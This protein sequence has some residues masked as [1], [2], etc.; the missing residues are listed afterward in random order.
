LRLGLEV[1]MRPLRA[2]FWVEALLATATGLLA[3]LTVLVP[4]WLE[5]AFG[6]EPDAG[7]GSVE[8]LIYFGLVVTVVFVVF[9]GMEWRRAAM[10]R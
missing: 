2:R 1:E 8:R 9:A 7:D 6:I 4:D 3:V 10:T 5:V